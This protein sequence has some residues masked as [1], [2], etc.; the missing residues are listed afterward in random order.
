M[1]D[2]Q[3]AAA[4]IGMLSGIYAATHPDALALSA[5]SGARTFGEL[6]ENANRLA[7]LLLEAGLQAGDAVAMIC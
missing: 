2:M 1:M 6:H 5:P 3:T 7:N 4:E